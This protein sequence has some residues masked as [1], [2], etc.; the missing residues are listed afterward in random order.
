VVGAD[1]RVTDERPQ[2]DGSAS[3]PARAA[4]SARH[5]AYF[6]FIDACGRPGCPV[7]RLVDDASRRYLAALLHEQVND[8]ETRRALR[9][10]GGFCNWHTWM[11][12]EVPDS[13]FGAAVLAEDVLARDIERFDGLRRLGARRR[14]AWA[15][16][17]GRIGRWLWP[18]A[19][20]APG[21]PRDRRAPCPACVDAAG[22]EARA[23]DTVLEFIGDLQFRRAYEGSTGLCAPHLALTLARA[24]DHP[25]AA[26]VLAL[27]LAR[28]TAQRRALE[29]F[30]GK[31]DYRRRAPFTE[32]ESAALEGALVTLA[33]I[34]GL[35]GNDL[36]GPWPPRGGRRP[37]FAPAPLTAGEDAARPDE[38]AAPAG[39]EAWAF[40]RARLELRI[41]ELT[42][43]L[44]EAS[45]RAAALHWRLSRVAEDRNVLEM[46][47]SGERGTARLAE[48]A[49][50]DLRA[51]SE[52]LRAEQERLRAENADLR[53]RLRAL[54][55]R[56]D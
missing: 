31:H 55:G 7:C 6:R 20:A 32:E 22:V 19:P 35:F 51:E 13:A 37:A 28:W 41:R 46:N 45:T 12:R 54:A 1:E 27:S 18:R 2:D 42:Q 33:G 52:R 48:R 50:A 9:S 5:L 16:L 24:G 25:A 4:L 49:L 21:A 8:V 3:S 26:E 43:Q 17:A 15:W 11:L 38:A 14:R 30:I 47:L 39:A 56:D 29:G 36:H 40:E 53:A 34:R 10:S 44:N 23:A